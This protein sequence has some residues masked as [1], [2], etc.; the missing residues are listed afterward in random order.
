MCASQAAVPIDDL[1]KGQLTSD[2]LNQI[3]QLLKERIPTGF[4]QHSSELPGTKSTLDEISDE[5]EPTHFLK[6]LLMQPT[7]AKQLGT[8]GG[9]YVD[10]PGLCLHCTILQWLMPVVYG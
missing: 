7:P 3:Q 4:N 5:V 8:L 6:D 2:Q 9:G 1:Y 10:S